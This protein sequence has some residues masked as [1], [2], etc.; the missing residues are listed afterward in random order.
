MDHL[1][2]RAHHRLSLRVPVM[3]PEFLGLLCL[4]AFFAIPSAAAWLLAD[5]DDDE[6]AGDE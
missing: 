3:S 4:I 5:K 6:E 1:W 2:H